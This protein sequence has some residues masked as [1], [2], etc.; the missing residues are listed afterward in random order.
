MAHF[1]DSD[2]EHIQVN[3]SYLF[4]VNDEITKA[5]NSLYTVLQKEGL[6][7]H[8]LALAQYNMRIAEIKSSN[9]TISLEHINL[10]IETLQCLD[11]DDDNICSCLLI[12]KI[13]NGQI[14]LVEVRDKDLLEVACEARTNLEH[15]L[16]FSE[17]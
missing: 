11:S 17:N 12:P 9:L 10:S 5:K 13:N 4:L 1:Y 6:N 16:K 2:D 3:L 15:W 7:S 14:S 8:L